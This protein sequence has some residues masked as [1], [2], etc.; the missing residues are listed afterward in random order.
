MRL[1]LSLESIIRLEYNDEHNV[2]FWLRDCL[3]LIVEALSINNE[4]Q[5]DYKYQLQKSVLNSVL[6]IQNW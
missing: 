1:L 5:N 3:I 4:L 2:T 6:I